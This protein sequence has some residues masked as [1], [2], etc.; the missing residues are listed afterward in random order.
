M[1]LP[2]I[3]TPCEGSL[4]AIEDDDKRCLTCGLHVIV[5]DEA[6]FPYAHFRTDFYAMGVRDAEAE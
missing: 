2:V 6:P 3:T 5:I 4:D 1:A